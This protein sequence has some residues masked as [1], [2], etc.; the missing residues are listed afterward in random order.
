M[1][2]NI[3][4]IDKESNL[5]EKTSTENL[6]VGGQAVIEGVMMRSSRYVAVAVRKSNGE[7]VLKKDP[8]ISLTKK[9]RF[10]NFPIVRGAIALVETLYIGIKALTFSADVLAQEEEGNKEGSEEIE[11]EDKVKSVKER[12]FTVFWIALSIGLGGFLAFFLFFYLPLILTDLLEIEKGYLFNLVDGAM[13]ILIFLA[14]LWLITIWKSMR[15]VFEYH[16]A[17]HKS[18]FALEKG[19]TLVA[20]NVK[21]YSTHHPRCGTSF[22]LIVM[23]I[24]I[25]IFMFLGRPQNIQERFIRFL[26]IPL[27]AGI[28]YEVIKFSGKKAAHPLVRVLISPGLWLQRITTKEPDNQQLEVAI[29]ALKS[30]L[31]D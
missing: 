12:I 26:F 2:D 25:G 13:R 31:E 8:F 29:A 22:L 5:K 28:S 16:G 18:I 1:D 19:D 17:E 11:K 30:S 10:L 9:Y 21:K 20:G 3:N 15:R 6:Q 4:Q 24:S 7:I 23:L 27:I 14:Y